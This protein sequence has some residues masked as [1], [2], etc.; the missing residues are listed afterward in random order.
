MTH[1]QFLS[2]LQTVVGSSLTPQAAITLVNNEQNRILAE[3]PDLARVHPDPY[4]ATL[5]STFLYTA[6]SSVYGDAGG[7]P[8]ALVGDIRELG[9]PYSQ[10]SS[11]YRVRY[12]GFGTNSRLAPAIKDSGWGTV[13]EYQ[14]DVVRSNRPLAND[15]T[16]RF[17]FQNTIS[18]T[19]TVYRVPCWL[20]PT[21]VTTA[22]NSLYLSI[23]E[24]FQSTLLLWRC[25][26]F[27]GIAQYGD[28][29]NLFQLAE[30]KLQE[31]KM[32]G[33]TVSTTT[34]RRRQVRDV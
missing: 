31:A 34:S 4:L 18:A 7:T 5:D 6:N 16:V 13:I 27:L 24:E 3:C 30:G 20:W 9:K 32:W 11:D 29:T 10:F 1:A 25:L 21:Q 23:P 17:W 33:L 15:C 12:N 26:L 2:M 28:I 8:G 14:A 19:T 22:S